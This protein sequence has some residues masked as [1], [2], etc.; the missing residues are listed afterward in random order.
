MT[1]KEKLIKI[2]KKNPDH[3]CK[4]IGFSKKKKPNQNQNKNKRQKI[5][6]FVA[7]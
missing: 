2:I 3:K 1:K 4:I 6:L 7:F 5:S